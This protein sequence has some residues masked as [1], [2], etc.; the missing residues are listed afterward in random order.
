MGEYSRKEKTLIDLYIPVPTVPVL[1]TTSRSSQSAA[2]SLYQHTSHP[3]H[4]IHNLADPRG[5]TGTQ[6]LRDM[7][8]AGIELQA[9]N[10]LSVQIITGT[11]PR[12]YGHTIPEAVEFQV[13][14]LTPC[15]VLLDFSEA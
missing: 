8:T 2:S 1:S 14:Q 3:T 7:G 10:L 15:E 5:P 12:A 6:A 4:A 11:G 13:S 9:R